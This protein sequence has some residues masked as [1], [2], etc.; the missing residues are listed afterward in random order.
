VTAS[1]RATVAPRRCCVTGAASKNL[2]FRDCL[3]CHA[4]KA[5]CGLAGAGQE[6]VSGPMAGSRSEIATIGVA[7]ADA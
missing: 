3:K 1:V 6:L 4:G 5:A 2:Q 7:P